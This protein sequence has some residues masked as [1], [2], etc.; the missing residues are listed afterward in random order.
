MYFRYSRSDIA[1]LVRKWLTAYTELCI[2]LYLR[3]LYYLIY[4]KTNTHLIYPG[5]LCATEG[6]INDFLEPREQPP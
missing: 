2:T 5:E 6:L 3:A 1:N 4:T